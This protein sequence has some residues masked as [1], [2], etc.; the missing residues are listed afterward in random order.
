MGNYDDGQAAGMRC[1]NR[2]VFR[3]QLSTLWKAL[4]Q[5]EREQDQFIVTEGKSQ[6]SWMHALF[7][8]DKRISWQGGLLNIAMDCDSSFTGDL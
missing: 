2:V 3:V 5:R 1:A 7:K 8:L 6:L 4:T